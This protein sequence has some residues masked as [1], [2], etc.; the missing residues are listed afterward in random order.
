VAIQALIWA[1]LRHEKAAPEAAS[2]RGQL[3]IENALTIGQ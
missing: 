1:Q 2:E 3:L